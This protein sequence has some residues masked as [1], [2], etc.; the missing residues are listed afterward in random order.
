MDDKGQIG[1]KEMAWERLRI[2]P[3]PKFLDTAEVYLSAHLAQN[4]RIYFIFA[5]FWCS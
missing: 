3:K 1:D 5:F 2:A 4:F